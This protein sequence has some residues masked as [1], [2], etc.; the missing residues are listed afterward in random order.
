LF[1]FLLNYYRAVVCLGCLCIFWRCIPTCPLYCIVEELYCYFIVSS[2]LKE[3]FK[4][5]FSLMRRLKSFQFVWL[6]LKLGCFSWFSAYAVSV[7]KTYERSEGRSKHDFATAKSWGIHFVTQTSTRSGS[8]FLSDGQDVGYP[9]DRCFKSFLS[10]ILSGSR[11]RG[12]MSLDPQSV[13]LHCIPL[14]H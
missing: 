3:R 13:G 8:L 11:P 7:I 6:L 1:K 2:V 9:I 12:V 10:I 5:T 14:L 4:I